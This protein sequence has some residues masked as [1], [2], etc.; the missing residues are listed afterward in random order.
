[1]PI[2]LLTARAAV[3]RDRYESLPPFLIITFGVAGMGALQHGFHKLTNWNNDF[4]VRLLI[5]SAF[6][7]THRSAAT[8]D[9]ERSCAT[10]APVG[11]RQLVQ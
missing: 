10:A 5:L 9:S 3:A 11:L 2:R 4:K 6:L 8:G 7:L 1:M